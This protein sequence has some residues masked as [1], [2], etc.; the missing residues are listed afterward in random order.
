[1]RFNRFSLQFDNFDDA[2][3]IASRAQCFLQVESEHQ[4]PGV[5]VHP[6]VLTGRG[7]RV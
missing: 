7:F 1:M 6:A 4:S 3:V 5:D 2:V